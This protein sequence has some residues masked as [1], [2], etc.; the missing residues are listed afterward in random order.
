MQGK[1]FDTY[2]TTDL[3]AGMTDFAKGGYQGGYKAAG[4]DAEFKALTDD[5]Y[6]RNLKV[7]AWKQVDSSLKN[8]K[9]L[10]NAARILGPLA[11]L[12]EGADFL[13]TAWGCLKDNK[14]Q[15]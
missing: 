6:K 15:K 12:A 13:I 9:S 7:G 10:K 14:L 5:W 4:G 8:L 11:M 1:P 2:G 3:V